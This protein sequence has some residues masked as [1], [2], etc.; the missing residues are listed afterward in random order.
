MKASVL[1]FVLSACFIAEEDD[2]DKLLS[3]AAFNLHLPSN[4]VFLIFLSH[5]ICNLK[6]SR[7]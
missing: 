2:D 7:E 3:E 6:V 5:G 1:F 4:F